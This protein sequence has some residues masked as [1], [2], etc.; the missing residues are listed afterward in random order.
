MLKRNLPDW[1]DSYKQYCHDSEPP[2]KYHEWCAV[3]VMAA[4]MQRKCKLVWGSI[5]HYPNFFIAIT[6]P[7]GDARKGTA[8]NFAREFVDDLNIPLAADA[9]SP[10]ALIRRLMESEDTE[11]GTP[12][13]ENYISTHSS[14]T[15]FSPELT[16]FLGYQNKEF[17]SILCDFYDCRAR[18]IYETIGRGTEEII[19]I[20]L[21]LIGATTPDLIQMAM[22]TEIV[23]SGL[24][25]RIIFVYEPSIRAKVPCPFYTQTDEG[26]ELKRKLTED[27]HQIK[28]LS[29]RFKVSKRYVEEWTK[30][31]TEMPINPPF[32]PRNFKH[33]WSRRPGHIVKLAMIFSASRSN[34]M[35]IRVKDLERAKSFITETEKNMPN[36]FAGMGR[37]NKSDIV[38]AIMRWIALKEEVKMQDLMAE[39][40]RDVD[41]YEMERIIKTL[42]T[43]KYITL[44]EKLGQTILVHNKP[45]K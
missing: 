6:G 38:S 15:C 26:K 32:D 37:S 40:V 14:L 2:T 45:I 30:F 23:G 7:A 1:F 4:A 27:L 12:E 44:V 13:A 5:T 18:F 20:Y 39:F 9:N 41:D 17:M 16:V 11:I 22:P 31:Y 35:V 36:V 34:E 43:M 19:G 33:Y 10:Q 3:S 21:N 25:S 8:M 24:S 29:G 28:S 42:R